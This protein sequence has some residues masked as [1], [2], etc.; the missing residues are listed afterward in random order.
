[1]ALKVWNGT[2]WQE[3]SAIKVWDGSAWASAT[4]GKVWD[5]SAWTNFFGGALV[6]LPTNIV[7]SAQDINGTVV[8][9]DVFYYA[10]VELTFFGAG[11]FA[12]RYRE[13]TADYTGTISDTDS[14]WLVSGT[15]SDYD[16]RISSLSGDS[17]NG[18]TNFTVNQ[19]YNLNTTVS[20]KYF[21]AVSLTGNGSDPQV[22]KS[23]QF[24]LELLSN[25]TSS[26]LATSY[27]SLDV[28]VGNVLV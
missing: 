19:K 8:G 26:V 2:A 1:M 18:T 22:T 4:A 13:F 10:Q 28:T 25:T 24:T 6:S 17:L 5:G 23:T 11:G 14:P 21:L 27:V 7:L 16:I 20:S 15:S 3:A 12:G 9:L